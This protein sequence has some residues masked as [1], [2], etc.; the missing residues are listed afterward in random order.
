MKDSN[1]QPETLARRSVQPDC[2]ALA[3]TI[4]RSIFAAG[5]EPGSPCKRIQFKGGKWPDN[6]RN[7]GGIGETPLV[8][9]I[10]AQLEA[11]NNQASDAPGSAALNREQ[12]CEKEKDSIGTA[13]G[14][15]CSTAMFGLPGTDAHE[16]RMGET[17]KTLGQPIHRKRSITANGSL[18]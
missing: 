2:Y 9:L 16:S 5:D 1:E 7:Q 3:V 8:A 4:A 15:F 17:W 11:H 10:A 13:E 14:A 6:E 12:S 18:H